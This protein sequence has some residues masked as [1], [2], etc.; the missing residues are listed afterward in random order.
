MAEDLPKDNDA[1]TQSRPGTLSPTK[2]PLKDE[3][4]VVFL[5]AGTIAEPGSGRQQ[6]CPLGIVGLMQGECVGG[7]M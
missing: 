6:P 2:D 7:L 4:A 3:E 1:R 5:A